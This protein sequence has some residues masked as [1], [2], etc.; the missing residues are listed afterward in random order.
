ML[1]FAYHN[2]NLK[3]LFVTLFVPRVKEGPISVPSFYFMYSIWQ[4]AGIRT[5]VAATAARFSTNE[6]HTSLR[7]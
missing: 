4:D 6:L 2:S 3:Q 5:L 7:S 1:L